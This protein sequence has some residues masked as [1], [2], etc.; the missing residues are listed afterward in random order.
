MASTASPKTSLYDNSGGLHRQGTLKRQ[1]SLEDAQQQPTMNGERISSR[2][3][4][5]GG[6]GAQ[7]QAPKAN[8]HQI[9][10]KSSSGNQGGGGGELIRQKSIKQ[11]QQMGRQQ[12]ATQQRLEN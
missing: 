10:K 4:N 3:H 6:Q 2:G 9:G 7:Q 12:S 11:Q 5:E 8:G 1:T